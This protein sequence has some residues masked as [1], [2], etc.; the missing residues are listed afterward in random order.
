MGEIKGNQALQGKT[1][2][3]KKLS[4][5]GRE[6]IF[7]LLLLL[8]SEAHTNHRMCHEQWPERCTQYSVASHQAIV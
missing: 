6:V 8:P 3:N 4:R 2:K 5:S 1:G 7:L